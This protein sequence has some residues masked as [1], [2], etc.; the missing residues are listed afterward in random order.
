MSTDNRRVERI[1][2]GVVLVEPLATVRTGVG[3]LID[4]ES[5]M[6]CLALV[7][8]AD[9]AVA[10][11][12]RLERRSIVL[13]LVSLALAEEHDA[14][15][16]IRTIRERFPSL[17]VVGFGAKSDKTTISRAL[18][19]GAD[20]F[21]DKSATATDFLDGLRR[22]SKGEV[23][24]VGPPPEWL[25]AISEAIGWQ[26]RSRSLL[27]EREREVL[28]IAAEGVTARAIG[29]RMGLAERTVTTHFA[30]IYSKL[31]VNNRI[32]AISAAE[33]SGLITPH[34]QG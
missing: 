9:E 34:Q 28:A 33:R 6:E 13:V 23:V 30:R 18:F 4:Q 12:G 2:L 20:G 16:L 14:S 1:K 24:L 29:E 8:S 10:E 5:D 25:G 15:W 11:L 22:A 17:A 27:T 21:I 3:M 31:G 26:R 7:G 19:V 32:A